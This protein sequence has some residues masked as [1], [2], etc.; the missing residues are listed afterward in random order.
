MFSISVW[1]LTILLSVGFVLLV[2][3]VLMVLGIRKLL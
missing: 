3:S 2:G 1:E